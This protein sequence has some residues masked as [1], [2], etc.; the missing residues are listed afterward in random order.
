MDYNSFNF[1]N[2]TLDKMSKNWPIKVN[3]EVTKTTEGKHIEVDKFNRLTGKGVSKEK[4]ITFKSKESPKEKYVEKQV[5]KRDKDLNW[6]SEKTSR[7]LSLG[8]KK[9]RSESSY[10]V[11]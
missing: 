3:R 2:S 11:Y 5:V 1:R 10:N 8:G 9:I 7:S 4:D 6:K